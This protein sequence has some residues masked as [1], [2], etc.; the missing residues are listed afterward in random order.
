MYGTK[1]RRKRAKVTEVKYERV[2][3]FL[4][5]DNWRCHVYTDSGDHYQGE[6]ISRSEARQNALDALRAND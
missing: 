4:D 6:G 2:P 1:E 5:S 3:C